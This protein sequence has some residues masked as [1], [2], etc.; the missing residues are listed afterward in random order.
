M[1]EPT[2]DEQLTAAMEDIAR[3]GLEVYEVTQERDDARAEV[4]R[5]RAEQVKRVRELHRPVVRN[6][7][8]D[9]ATEVTVC[10][11]CDGIREKHNDETAPDPYPCATVRAL[12]ATEATP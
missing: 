1:S 3:L 6:L 12:D 2:A 5:L 10:L 8:D 4:E 11:E 9:G 7:D